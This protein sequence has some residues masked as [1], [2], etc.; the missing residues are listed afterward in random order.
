MK[1][2][3]FHAIQRVVK[4]IP[5]R[6]N[7]A[8]IKQLRKQLLT[9]LRLCF[10]SPGDTGETRKYVTPKKEITE[11]NVLKFVE[12][13]K[14]QKV[15]NIKVLPQAAIDAVDKLFVHITSGIPPG[16]GT[17][18]NERLHRKIR[19]WLNRTHIGVCLV[20]APLSMV[21]YHHMDIGRNV[22]K[23]TPVS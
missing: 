23:V 22:K 7:N 19:K 6:Q 15:D 20:V 4:G 16:I 12:K 2:D 13:W 18:Q 21:F 17:N 9:D 1:L 14:I 5:K 10:R 11:K 8:L 3:V